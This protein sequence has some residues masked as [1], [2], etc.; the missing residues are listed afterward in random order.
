ME[1]QAECRLKKVPDELLDALAKLGVKSRT[2]PLGGGEVLCV[3]TR[4]ENKPKKKV[5]VSA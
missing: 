1:T 3:L 2:Q 4:Q 5:K